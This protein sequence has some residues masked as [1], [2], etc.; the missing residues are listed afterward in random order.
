M[1]RRK[2]NL[3]PELA[4][5]VRSD[6][7]TAIAAFSRLAQHRRNRLL[8]YLHLR[9]F[10]ADETIYEQGDPPA[11]IFFLLSGSVNLF[12]Q[13]GTSRRD[14]IRVASAGESLGHAALLPAAPQLESAIAAEP[15][16]LLVLLRADFDTLKIK[17]P[18]LAT[19]ILQ[20]V[21]EEVLENACLAFTAYRGLT[22]QLTAANIIV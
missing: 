3:S 5:Q 16:K 17:E 1:N 2:K 21:L 11:A 13:E 14:R 4:E 22:N 20:G 9:T 10:A 15:V 7:L 18:I 12:H 19:A 8:P 6:H